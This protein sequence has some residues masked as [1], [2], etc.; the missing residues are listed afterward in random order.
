MLPALPSLRAVLESVA[1]ERAKAELATHERVRTASRAKG[2]VAIEPVLPV[3]LL[4]TYV[5]LPLL[6][7]VREPT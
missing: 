6:P 3:D 4:D 7:A 1:H 5:L 2:R